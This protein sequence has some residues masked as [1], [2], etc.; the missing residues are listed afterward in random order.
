MLGAAG[1]P[2]AALCFLHVLGVWEAHVWGKFLLLEPL[3]A[4]EGQAGSAA[5]QEHAGFTGHDVWLINS[6]T[7]V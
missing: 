1:V 5:G 4:P 6:S 3:C 2:V 7:A